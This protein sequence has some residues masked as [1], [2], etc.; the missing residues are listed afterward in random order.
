MK[1]L[2]AALQLS[3]V[4]YAY[5]LAVVLGLVACESPRS[6]LKRTIDEDPDIVLSVIEKHP[7][8]FFAAVNKADSAAKENVAR[9]QFAPEMDRMK[10]ELKTP[11]FY[12][13]SPDR[14]VGNV[15]APIT[16]VEYS[17]YS[18][19]H[20][21]AAHKTMGALKQKYGD[22]IRFVFKH[23]PILAPRSRA[24]AEYTEA[25][26]LQDPSLAFRFRQA[27]YENQ[28]D[29]IERNEDFLVEVMEQIGADVQKAKRDRPS[30]A[31]Q[32]VLDADV[33]EAR[34]SNF[35]GT[36]GF[37][38]NGVAIRGSYPQ[39]YFEMAFEMMLAAKRK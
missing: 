14:V 9:A 34:E 26:R 17:D 35:T 32:A 11:A 10:E 21:A 8:A 25:L 7:E 31:V 1:S 6:K 23:L 3:R 19:E 27:L 4:R 37:L 39:L 13:V 38:V 29:L 28:S 5:S 20:C 33:A 22:S 30:S 16:I 36:P 2:L 18:C 24:A 12:V 15:N